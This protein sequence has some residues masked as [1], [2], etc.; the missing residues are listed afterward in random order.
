[1]EEGLAMDSVQSTIAQA[2]GVVGVSIMTKQLPPGQEQTSLS[3]DLRL[4]AISKAVC[5]EMTG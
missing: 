3:V 1:M 2:P 5:D 4:A